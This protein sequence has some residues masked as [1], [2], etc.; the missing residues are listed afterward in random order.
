MADDGVAIQELQGN[1]TRCYTW[2]INFG[3][4]LETKL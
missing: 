1:K 2:K 3:L 4:D